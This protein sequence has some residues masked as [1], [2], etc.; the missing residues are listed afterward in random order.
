MAGRGFSLYARDLLAREDLDGRVAYL[1]WCTASRLEAFFDRIDVL[2]IPSTYE[3]FGMVALEAMSR[4][5]P[6]VCPRS[7]GLVE[8]LGDHAYYYDG[9]G[10]EAFRSA[11][12][13]WRE[14]SAH[15]RDA[16]A[17]AACRRHRGHFT[18]L[19]MARGY[20]AAYAQITAAASH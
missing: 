20:A 6:V 11:M 7:G 4:G 18:D 5:V 3:P 14:S 8:A 2:A 15:E 17:Q 16:L 10:F 19:H 12:V 9:T 1:G 13:R